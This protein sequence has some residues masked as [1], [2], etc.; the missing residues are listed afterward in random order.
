MYF[1]HFRLF[2]NDMEI[3]YKLKTCIIVICLIFF[4]NDSL[5][6]LEAKLTNIRLNNTRDNLIIYLNIEGAF[7]VKMEKAILAGVPA[8]FTYY[9]KL[10]QI[11]D[12]WFDKEVTDIKAIHTIRYDN[13]KKEFH[14][15]RS[16]E[17]TT[18]ILTKSF[19]DAKLLMNQ[20]SGLKLVELNRLNKSEQY[21]ILAK[22]ELSKVTLPLYLHYVLFF[23]SMWDFET[24]WHSIDFIY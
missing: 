1:K 8:S 17:N 14:I 3:K 6:A 11:R 19:L 9:I 21:R 2:K 10:Y 15:N 22:A 16:W 12:F 18:P 23:V 20:I 4:F 13:L 24:D 7:P 5:F